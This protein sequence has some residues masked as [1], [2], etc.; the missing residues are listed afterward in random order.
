MHTNAL[1]AQPPTDADHP[2]PAPLPL[3]Q[4]LD[5]LLA[6]AA[7]GFRGTLDPLARTVANKLLRAR[8]W[9][10][11]CPFSRGPLARLSD[12]AL[13]VILNELADQL[14]EL[15]VEHATR[16]AHGGDPLPDPAD[17]LAELRAVLSAPAD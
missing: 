3:R 1:E 4:R 11:E 10:W 5:A 13:L 8:G 7:L 15:I 12:G 14:D 17:A 2:S 16:P 9:T 6:P